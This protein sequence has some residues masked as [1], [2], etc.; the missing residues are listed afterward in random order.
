MHIQLPSWQ[1]QKIKTISSSQSK[2]AQKLIMQSSVEKAVIVHSHCCLKVVFR[3]TVKDKTITAV[4][5]FRSLKIL[6]YSIINL[7]PLSGSYFI[8]LISKATHLHQ[9]SP[10]NPYLRIFFVHNSQSKLRTSSMAARSCVTS[11]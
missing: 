8:S 9:H 6:S 3:T 5:T 11:P 1:H 2:T 4:V 10:H 7:S